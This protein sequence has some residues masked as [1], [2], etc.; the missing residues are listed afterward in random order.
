MGIKEWNQES[1]KRRTSKELNPHFTGSMGVENKRGEKKQWNM[2]PFIQLVMGRAK[3]G[4]REAR[5]PNPNP[6]VGH[7]D[8]ATKWHKAILTAHSNAVVT[9]R[10]EEMP[11]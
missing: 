3:V 10:S 4:I 6:L 9:A 8:R 7:H 5:S 2:H 1:D 11:G